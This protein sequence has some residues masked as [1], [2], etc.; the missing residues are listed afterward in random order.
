MVEYL[1]FAPHPDDVELG[2]AAMRL[3]EDARFD[4][5]LTKTD[6]PEQPHHPEKIIY[7]Y[8][9]HLRLHVDP[10]F[11]VDVSSAYPRKTAALEAYESQ[12]FVSRGSDAGKVP[13]L[14]RL[15]DRYFGG[16]IGIEFGEPFRTHE[17]VGLNDPGALR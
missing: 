6:I 9:T 14:I 15:R 4:A 13:D 16:R 17:L 3:I 11:V 8:C 5:K 1:V 10:S 12:F 2:M 7:Y